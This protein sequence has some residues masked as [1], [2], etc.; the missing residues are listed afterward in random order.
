M[1]GES[2]PDMV[3]PLD[4]VGGFGGDTHIHVGITFEK[5]FLV[6][7]KQTIANELARAT[8]SAL[9]RLGPGLAT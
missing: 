9:E 5:G 6:G 2:G 7:S 8:Q 4:R 3:V 1:I